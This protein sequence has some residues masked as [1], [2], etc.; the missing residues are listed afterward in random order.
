MKRVIKANRDVRQVIFEDENFEVR[1]EY[2]V[3]IDDTPFISVYVLTKPR[4]LAKKHV[5][6]VRLDTAGGFPNYRYNGAYV[7]HGMRMTSDTLD[8]TREYI[9]VLEDAIDFAERVDAWL[10]A[11]KAQIGKEQRELQAK[12]EQEVEVNKGGNSY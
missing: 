11:N 5:V 10:Q 4:S 1:K 9:A 3:G 12:H 8:E 7:A 6:E 2:G